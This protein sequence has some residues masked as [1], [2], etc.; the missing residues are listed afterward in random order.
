[1]DGRLAEPSGNHS[2]LGLLTHCPFHSL[3]GFNILHQAPWTVE[4]K[5]VSEVVTVHR[6]IDKAALLS[7]HLGLRFRC[8]RCPCQQQWLGWQLEGR[9]HDSISN[10][11]P[12]I[13]LQQ[14]PAWQDS[15]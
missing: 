6:G 3:M 7:P 15:T 5:G 12:F 9:A 11:R 1:M 14:P 8:R 10:H 4:C 13:D 2:H